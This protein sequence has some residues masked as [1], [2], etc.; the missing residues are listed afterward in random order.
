MRQP[1]RL[2]RRP[3]NN[4]YS[5][6]FDA[7]GRPGKFTPLAVQEFDQNFTKTGFIPEGCTATYRGFSFPFSEGKA[8]GLIYLAICGSGKDA[9]LVSLNYDLKNPTPEQQKKLAEIT[10]ETIKQV[11]GQLAPQQQK[12][13][14]ALK[15]GATESGKAP[16]RQA[17]KPPSSPP[18]PVAPCT[19]AGR[20]ARTSS[21]G[22]LHFSGTLKAAGN[23]LPARGAGPHGIYAAGQPVYRNGPVGAN[24]AFASILFFHFAVHL[25]HCPENRHPRRLACLGAHPA[26][27][28]HDPVRRNCLVVGPG[29]LCRA[30]PF[31]AH[32]LAQCHRH[33]RLAAGNG[34]FLCR[35]LDADSANAWG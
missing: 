20:H 32:S 28:S 24:S 21:T 18:V 13:P 25:S 26:D 23:G 35:G 6:F 19:K 4:P 17:A 33:V 12:T 27:F 9:K 30:A 16:A 11:A 7:F 31:D 22:N 34:D 14:A 3:S 5:F 8:T 15:P 10:R 2:R 1:T 29:Y